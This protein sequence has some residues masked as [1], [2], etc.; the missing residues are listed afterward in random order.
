MNENGHQPVS[1]SVN[2]SPDQAMNPSNQSIID[3][4]ANIPRSNTECIS[5]QFSRGPDHHNQAWGVGCGHHGVQ[6]L[7]T[8]ALKL[9]GFPLTPL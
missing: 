6:V 4:L 9:L 8:G 7:G 1:E 2:Q 3:C 5:W